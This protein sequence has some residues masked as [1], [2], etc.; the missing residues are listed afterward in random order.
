MPQRLFAYIWQVSGKHQ[1]GL[2]ALS[3]VVF[4]LAAAPLELQRRIVNGA[5]ERGDFSS[6][7]MLCL[8]Y[9]GLAVLAGGIKLS[10]NTYRAWVGETLSRN[11]RATVYGMAIE[12]HDQHRDD[13]TRRADA[14]A[15][16]IAEVDAVGGFAGISF[17]EPI[18]QGG[19]LLSVVGYMLV[20]QPKMAALSLLLLAPQLVFV[21]LMQSAITRRVQIRVQKTR[22]LG[23]GLANNWTQL[24][25][26]AQESFAHRAER[27]F[28]LNMQIARFKYV[29]NFLM[30]SSHHLSIAA[31]LLVGGWF[32]VKGEIE[33]GTVVAFISGLSRINDPWGDLVNYFRE[34]TLA[35]TKYELV[36][37]VFGASLAESARSGTPASV[38]A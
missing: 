3:V 5:L 32:V 38:A 23:A 21:P 10:L 26:H 33:L 28:A 16:Q 27:I 35:E 4:L 31:V 25:G 7:L 12:S 15:V 29:M 19:I 6:V 24:R 8:G 11:L 34:L 9:I 20:L 22:R 36:R 37:A 13:Q 1:L 18:L 14:L 30:N 2:A 17:S